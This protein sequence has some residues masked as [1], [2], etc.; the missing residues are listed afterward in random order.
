MSYKRPGVFVEESLK[1][2]AVSSSDPSEFEAAFVGTSGMGPIQPTRVTS[3]V[4]YVTRF[5]GFG[6]GADLLPFAV[7]QYFNN[8]GHSAW[9]VRGVNANA[10]AATVGLNNRAAI[11][12]LT[13]TVTAIS[14]G[15]WGNGVSVSITAVTGTGADGRFNLIVNYGGTGDANVV[16][17][18]LDVSLD[19]ADG[20]Y[21]INVVNSS[22]SGSH[23]VRLTDAGGAY[24]LE[25]APALVN[26]VSLATGSDGTGTP[27]LAA[28]A[29]KLEIVSS[30]LIL[31]IPGVNDG[32]T[33]N[34]V[35]TWAAAQGNVFVVVDGPT[36]AH[37]TTADAAATSYI[38]A[39][40]GL[41]TNSQVSMYGPW[42]RVDD[43]AGRVPGS[44]RVLPPGGAVMGQY[45]RTDAS[46]GIQKA[47]AGLDTQLRGVLDVE[48]KWHGSNLD[49][50]NERGV[51]VIRHVP[52]AGICIM[53]AR[54]LKTGMPDRYVNIRR[55]LMYIRKSLID[56]TRF[57]IFEANNSR[58][59]DELEA[60][61]TQY[62]T[63]LLQA[64]VLAGD[65]PDE[66]FFVKCDAENNTATQVAS[67]TVV[68]E[69]GV[70][71]AAPAEFIIIKIG[72]FEGGATATEATV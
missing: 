38:T 65:T 20:R 50:L 32:G 29:Q 26:N 5:G 37:G 21:V 31:N 70:A 71:L 39:A 59:W 19:P 51:N 30:N 46:R 34:P 55:S 35:G 36:V 17:R 61:V 6:S 18:F 45:I 2:L 22:V 60:V 28:T 12:A 14:P 4:N 57:S 40:N 68:I 66:A 7:F 11:P 69:V 48:V 72:Q 41:T 1:P 9:I 53:G 64:G 23:Y 47:P 62:L 24:T 8:G 33:I 63:G 44:M 25:R 16:E 56:S 10:V 15:V 49:A 13:L 27:D 42:L 52:G 43:P 58:L 3:W 67:G 54:T